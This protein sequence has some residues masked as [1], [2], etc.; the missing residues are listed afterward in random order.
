MLIEVD[1]RGAEFLWMEGLSIGRG[2]HV[3]IDLEVSTLQ[4][5][6]H[7]RRGKHHHKG[8]LVTT[9]MPYELHYSIVK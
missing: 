2:R 1:D 5:A 4:S 9:R 8:P 6:D 3:L 7:S